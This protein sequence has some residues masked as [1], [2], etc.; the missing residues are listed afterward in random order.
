MEG[1]LVVL[2]EPAVVR[3]GR[4]GWGVVWEWKWWWM[5]GDAIVVCK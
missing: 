5:F 1:L 3:S 2:A 4:E